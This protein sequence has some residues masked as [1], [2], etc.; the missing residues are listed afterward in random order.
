MEGVM[1]QPAMSP[2]EMVVMG[3]EMPVAG[4]CQLLLTLSTKMGTRDFL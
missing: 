3:T 4:V 1:A 2:L